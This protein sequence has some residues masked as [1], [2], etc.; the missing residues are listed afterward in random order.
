MARVSS[1]STLATAVQTYLGRS[2]VGVSAGN[3]DYLCAEAEEEMNARVRVRFM[4]TAITPTVSSAGVITLPTGFVGWKRFQCRDGTREWDLDLK[5]AEQMTEIS[6][7]YGGSNGE[8]KAVITIGTTS[9]IW[10]YTDA[11]YTFRALHYLK[12]PELSSGAATNWVITNYPNAYLYGCLAAARAFVNDDQPAM[13]SRFDLWEKRFSRAIDRI[14][15]ADAIDL[16]A[17]SHATLS[18]DTSLFS[19]R[20]HGNITVDE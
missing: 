19:G 7:L 6:P 17:R 8:P 16:D 15:I 20:G 9:Q 10:P 14:N 3:L 13:A 11:V 5:S 2:D 4:L 1:Y 18:A 12:I